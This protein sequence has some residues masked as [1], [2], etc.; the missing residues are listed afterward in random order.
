MRAP[1]AKRLK[2]MLK[3]SAF[4]QNLY[5]VTYRYSSKLHAA[6]ERCWVIKGTSHLLLTNISR[7]KP[8][9]RPN[10]RRHIYFIPF[11]AYNEY[12][13]ALAVIFCIATG[14]YIMNKMEKNAKNVEDVR[15]W[16]EG[17]GSCARLCL[18]FDS[19]LAHHLCDLH[20]NGL[21]A[22]RFR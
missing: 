19:A 18:L 4:A 1:C 15:A 13:D 8:L 10:G 20:S 21:F 9:K 7:C 6:R 11:I 12:E 16:G 22:V 17:E 2:E 14:N 3:V 5:P